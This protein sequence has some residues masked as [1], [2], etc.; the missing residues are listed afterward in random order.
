MSSGH[1]RVLIP[2]LSRFPASSHRFHNGFRWCDFDQ[3]LGE[4]L[5]WWPTRSTKTVI[6]QNALAIHQGSRPQVSHWPSRGQ[7]CDNHSALWF[8]VNSWDHDLDLEMSHTAE[9]CW[10]SSSVDVLVVFWYRN[11]LGYDAGLFCL[12]FWLVII[13]L[14]LS[15]IVDHYNKPTRLDNNPTGFVINH[16]KPTGLVELSTIHRICQSSMEWSA[17]LIGSVVRLHP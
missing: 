6:I 17:W 1:Q 5:H 9:R 15:I 14:L 2:L 12:L 16:Y 7:P 10:E 3:S 4:T 13:P 8:V 11:M